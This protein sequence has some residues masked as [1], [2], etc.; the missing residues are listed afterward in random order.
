MVRLILALIASLSFSVGASAQTVYVILW[1]DTEDYVLPASDDA[2]LKVAEWLT[3]EGV[4]ATFKVVGE[5]ARTLEKR[6]RQDVI[7]ALKKHEI[8]YHSN[9][10]SVPP[11][12]AQYLSQLGWDEGVAE[13]D[14]RE[15]PGYNDV[16][17]LF[18]QSPTCYGQPGSSWGPQSFGALRK[19]KTPVYLDAGRHVG[20]DGKPHY[21]GGVLTLYHLTH[22]LR[23]DLGG[24]KDLA[25]AEE[26]FVEARKQLLAEGGGIVS[27]YY[28]PCEFVH[29]QFWD[30][31]NF[32]KGANPPREK[33]QLP[34]AKTDAE[35]RLAYETFFG[36]VRFMKR[37][38]DVKFITASQAREVYYRDPSVGRS[39]TAQEIKSIAAAVGDEINFQ[40]L[41]DLTLAPS[42]I[43]QL[44]NS[45][46][47]EKAAGQNPKAVALGPTPFGPTSSPPA[48]AKAVTTDA[49]QFTRTAAD[50]A[51]AIRTQGRVPGTVWLGSTG[52]T[53][54]AYLSALARVVM[55]LADG[56]GVPESIEL[57]PTKLACGKYVVDDDPRLWN[58]VIFPPDFRAPA[59]M[60]LARR[61]AWTIKPAVLHNR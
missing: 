55:A 21:F 18:G 44:L 11:T 7:D 25:K 54:E 49:S 52:V 35:S 15:K 38:P 31:A 5:K 61:Q 32:S 3:K 22:T 1:F 2:A 45:Y 16:K 50:V 20:L 34:L 41:D 13:F 56:K 12:P 9:F 28:H 4:P 33:W 14:R 40:K 57:T 30:G 42:E 43:L 51:D 24:E 58:W 46:L 39:F 10:H 47:V 23:S 48:M 53:P 27:T 59:M 29:K 19:W 60:E 8:G 26:K 17:R 36:Y 6:G 37:F